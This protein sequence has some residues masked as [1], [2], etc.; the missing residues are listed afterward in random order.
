MKIA[1][2]YPALDT[3]GGADRVLTEKANYLANECGYDIYIITTHQN[4]KPLFFPLSTKVKH[5]DLGVDFNKQ[6]NHSFLLRG[7]TYF[8]LLRIYKKKLSETLYSLRPDFTITTI[9]RDIDFLTNI[10]D[11]SKKIAEAHTTKKNLRNLQSM[12][13]KG[14]LYKF[15]GK[16]W[17]RK[18]EKAIATFDAFVVLTDH[19]AK[20][21]EK[22]K[23][24][25]VIPNSLPFNPQN[26]KY[27]SNKKAISIGRLEI[28]KGH[29]RLIKVWEYVVKK[30]PDWSLDIYGEGTLKETL[31]NEI[32]YRNLENNIKIKTPVSNIF[33][34]YNESSFYIMTSRY[35]GFGMVLAE[36]MIHGLPCISYNCPDGPRYIINDGVDGFL[37]EDGNNQLMAEKICYLIEHE[38]KRIE[39][40]KKAKINIQRYKSEV[41]MP[42]WIDL[43]NKIK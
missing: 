11:G 12:I 7:L 32:K 5:I 10:K 1:Y 27:N 25:F 37:I 21:W 36:A 16:L 3:V 18:M 39:M 43:F 24:A 31:L 23:K 26:I 22:I 29:D 13:D 8:K 33:E 42:Q 17:V 19:D 41:I 28:E 40:G 38:D 6:Y 15:I 9:S 2:I 35:E 4:G 14:G 20:E 30:H 34:K